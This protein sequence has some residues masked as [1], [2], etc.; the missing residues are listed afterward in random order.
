MSPLSPVYSSV[1]RGTSARPEI[2]RRGLPVELRNRP[3]GPTGP[4]GKISE[5]IRQPSLS[6]FRPHGNPSEAAQNKR[7]ITGD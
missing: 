3:F 5:F 2:T 6:D 1:S 4:D 7:D